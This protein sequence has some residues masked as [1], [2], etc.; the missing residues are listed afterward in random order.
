MCIGLVANIKKAVPAS[1]IYRNLTLKQKGRHLFKRCH[2]LCSHN[3]KSS[4]LH[5]SQ[6]PSAAA[7]EGFR[8]GPGLYSALKL[9][10]GFAS[11]ALTAWKLTVA[12]AITTAIK[13]T[14]P[15][16]HQLMCIR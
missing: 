2:P 12:S 4:P 16:I 13:T 11:A 9:F 14:N 6:V 5:S 15:N 1:A 10:T 7:E 3:K 8:V